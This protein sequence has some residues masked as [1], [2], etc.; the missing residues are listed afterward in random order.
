MQLIYSEIV[1]EVSAPTGVGRVYHGTGVVRLGDSSPG[2]RARLDA[3]ARLL[4][5]VA[6]DDARDAGFGDF[7]WVV[8]R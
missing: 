6:D 3:I 2:G 1:F 4:Q 5:D 7:A 8:R